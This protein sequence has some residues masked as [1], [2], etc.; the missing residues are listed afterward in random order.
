MVRL[1]IRMS[2][3]GDKDK[4]INVDLN[5]TVAQLKAQMRSERSAHLSLA[6]GPLPSSPLTSASDA[7]LE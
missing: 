6:I 5:A 3:K 1:T 4:S 7:S 2:P